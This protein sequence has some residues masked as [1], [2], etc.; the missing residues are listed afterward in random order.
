MVYIIFRND[1]GFFGNS[2]TFLSQ[3]PKL[4]VKSEYKCCLFI[5]DTSDFVFPR[6][7]VQ[8]PLIER[9]TRWKRTK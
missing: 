5:K 4:S 3:L 9:A 7:K 2:R 6:V 8:S 1:D